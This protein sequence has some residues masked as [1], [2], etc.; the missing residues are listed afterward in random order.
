MPP[1]MT[2]AQKNAIASPTAWMMVYDT[3]LNAFS[4]YTTTWITL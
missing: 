2:T 1:R 4:G 3:T